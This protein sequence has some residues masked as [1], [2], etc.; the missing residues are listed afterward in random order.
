LPKGRGVVNRVSKIQL[1]T[2]TKT[3]GHHVQWVELVSVS[4][5]QGCSEIIAGRNTHVYLPT[6]YFLKQE[7]TYSLLHGYSCSY[8]TLTSPCSE[9]NVFVVWDIIHPLNWAWQDWASE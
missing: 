1:Q 6:S 3:T 7:L 9:E 2:D 8:Q 4:S 5:L